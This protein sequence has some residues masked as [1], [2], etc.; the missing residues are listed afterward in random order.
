MM[1][2]ESINEKRMLM[3]VAVNGKKAVLLLDTG[4]SVGLL[5][6][7]QKKAYKLIEA[8]EY[9]GSVVGAGGVIKRLYRCDTLVDLPN[10]KKC[11]QFLLADISQIVDSIKRETGEE[12]IGIMS[13]RQMKESN[14]QIDF[15]D[16]QII[17]E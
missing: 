8:R 17:F 13:L 14:M 3:Q 4:A 5:D 16:N 9:N 10:G 12:I 7:K 15:N 6:S 2:I 1:T 11:G